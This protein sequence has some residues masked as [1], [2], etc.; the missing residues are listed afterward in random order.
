MLIP[1]GHLRLFVPSGSPHEPPKLQQWWIHVDSG[2]PF[3]FLESI[4]ILPPESWHGG[5]WRDVQTIY[6]ESDEN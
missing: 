3:E 4:G 6:G 2:D 5:E 1:S